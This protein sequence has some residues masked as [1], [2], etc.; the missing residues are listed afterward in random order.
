MAEVDALRDKEISSG[1]GGLFVKFEQ[2]KPLKL[3]VLTIDPIVSKD[4]WGGTKYAFIV[5]NHTEQKAQILNKGTSIANEI[6]KLHLDDD[7]G[8]NIQKIDIKIEAEGSGKDTKYTVNPVREAVELTQEQIKEARD[9]RLEDAV[10]N[11]ARLSTL[12][13]DSDIPEYIPNDDGGSE[14]PNPKAKKEVVIEDI[15]DEPVDLSDIP[16]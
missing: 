5:Y 9:I 10:K 6:K 15:D 16:F 11:G 4:Q 13:S 1:G 7:W 12:E 8:G 3:R 2:G 14:S